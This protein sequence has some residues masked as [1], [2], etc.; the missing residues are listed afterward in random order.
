[1]FAI[2]AQSHRIGLLRI[3]AFAHHVMVLSGLSVSTKMS[4]GAGCLLTVDAARAAAAALCLTLASGFEQR[5]NMFWD[6]DLKLLVL[7]F[8]CVCETK[9]CI[10]MGIVSGR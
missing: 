9:N 3:L 2:I 8:A 6:L 10:L 1:M 4:E 5:F 7:L